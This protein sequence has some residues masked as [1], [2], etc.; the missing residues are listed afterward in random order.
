MRKLLPLLLILLGAGA[1]VGAG[2]FLRPPPAAAVEGEHGTEADAQEDHAEAASDQLPEFVKLS[3][4]FIV[5]VVEK[6][7]IASLV[8]LSLS[9]EVEPGGTE[10]VFAQEPKLRDGILQLLFDHANT[11]GFRGSFTDA[12]NLVILRRGL[13]EVAQRVL[14]EM[15][16]DVLITDMIRQDS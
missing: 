16:K 5:P 15:V 7:R 6:N 10:R 12:D 3:N 13:K 11:G 8:I 1:G 9:L 4:Q 2:F 14:G